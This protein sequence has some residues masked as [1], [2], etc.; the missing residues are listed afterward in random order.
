MISYMAIILFSN[1]Y[2]NFLLYL[3]MHI[4]VTQWKHNIVDQRAMYFFNILDHVNCYMT[5]KDYS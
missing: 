1:W 3:I 5:E 2:I 4:K